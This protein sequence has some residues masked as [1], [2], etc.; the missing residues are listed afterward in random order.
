MLPGKHFLQSP[1]HSPVGEQSIPPPL[2][3]HAELL[4]RSQP[5]NCWRDL[6]RPLIRQDLHWLPGEPYR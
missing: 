5:G 1:P 3:Y 6:L 2:I 4:S